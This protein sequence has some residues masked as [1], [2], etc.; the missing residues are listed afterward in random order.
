MCRTATLCWS[1]ADPTH[2]RDTDAGIVTI[3]GMMALTGL[4]T[5]VSAFCKSIRGLW[6]VRRGTLCGPPRVLTDAYVYHAARHQGI[7]LL[8]L[9]LPV[10]SLLGGLLVLE[11]EAVPTAQ[12]SLDDERLAAVAAVSGSTEGDLKVCRPLAQFGCAC[13]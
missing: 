3:G 13:L 9:C 2:T 12:V 1:Y 4:I 7:C 8:L 10:L 6:G 5:L 11:L